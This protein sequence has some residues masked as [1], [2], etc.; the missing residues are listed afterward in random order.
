MASI[1]FFIEF[2]KHRCITN[3]G[4]IDLIRWMRE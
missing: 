2:D 3:K 4:L 1:A